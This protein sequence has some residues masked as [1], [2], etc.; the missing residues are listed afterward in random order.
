ME[1]IEV[2][3]VGGGLAGLRAARRLAE[4]GATVRLFE[5]ESSVGGRVR[6]ERRG[7]YRIDRG[8]QVLFT[9]YPELR[10]AVD[11][12]ELDL[13]TFPP[14]AVICSPNHRSVVADPRREPTA[15]FETAFS[16]DLWIGDKFRVLALARELAAA[17][18]GDGTEDRDTTIEEYLDA[19][20]FSDRFVERFA[21]PFFGGIT[22]DRS[23]Q[24]SSSVFEF[25]FSMLATGRVALPADGVGAVTAQLADRARSAGASV[26][27]D[28]A[29]TAV[30]AT[31]RGAA[32]ELDGDRLDVDAVV[33][34][35]D[36]PTSAALTGVDSIPTTGK[37]CVTQYLR[38]PAGNPI[39]EQSH[40]LLNAGGEVPNQVAPLSAVAP[41]Y[42]PDDEILLSATTL[43]DR[44]EPDRELFEI[45][46]TTLGRWYPEASFESMDLLETVRCPFAQY[47]QPPGYRD[48]LPDVRAPEGPIYLAG[49]YTEQSSINGALESG[50]LAAE[51]IREDR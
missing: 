36:P 33:V 24:T 49:D 47:A 35:A 44:E 5:R 9:A 20:G 48:S 22:L 6:S 31:P 3:V 23:L 17:P 28:A 40:L 13:R 7:E 26:E 43:G 42:A 45:T 30:E 27:T 34:A 21:E 38:L 50:R 11:L 10:D 2:A 14:G 32:I 29:V 15:L 4:D 12:D 41:E 37:A 1:S 51:A 8:F 16:R 46:R 18:T 39:G 19:R 25:V